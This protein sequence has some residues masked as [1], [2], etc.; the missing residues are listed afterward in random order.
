[1][2]QRFV[3]GACQTTGA[4]AFGAQVPACRGWDRLHTAVCD[5]T[6][7]D[8]AGM[9]TAPRPQENQVYDGTLLRT[10]WSLHTCPAA[11]DSGDEET[12]HHLKGYIMTMA[13]TEV[14]V[15]GGFPEARSMLMGKVAFTRF[16][17]S[18][19]RVGTAIPSHA[20]SKRLISASYG[21]PC[22]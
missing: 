15:E 5:H 19:I 1:M 8:S 22:W 2:A 12:L 16:T 3:Y 13:T 9:D 18:L 4:N 6:D 14:V 20:L 7:L 11:S 10:S 21:G 17:H